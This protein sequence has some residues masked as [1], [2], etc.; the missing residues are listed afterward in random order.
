ME[1][2]MHMVLEPGPLIWAVIIGLVI[3]AAAIVTVVLVVSRKKEPE[4]FI[5]LKEELGDHGEQG[6]ETREPYSSR[7]MEPVRP[8]VDDDI[9]TR[10]LFDDHRIGLYSYYIELQD[11]KTGEKYT[12]GIAER[13]RLG[14]RP[15]CNIVVN[16]KTVSNNHCEVAIMNGV[17]VLR[18]LQSVNGT[19]IN[20]MKITG[21]VRLS[22]GV[23]LR[24]GQK[25]YL[26]TVS[27]F[28]RRQEEW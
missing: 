9:K 2:A 15:D 27:D 26:V 19:Y 8:P 11:I 24:L 7:K 12:C 23:I 3:A 21:D 16:H 6:C 17:P 5:S 28:R 18:D 14:R 4:R 10:N 20:G 1:Q 25:E 22:S 13:I